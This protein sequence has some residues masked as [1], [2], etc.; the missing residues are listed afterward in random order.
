[1]KQTLPIQGPLNHMVSASIGEVVCFRPSLS[2]PRPHVLQAA[3]LIRVPTE[4]IKT[5]TQTS[6]YGTSAASS[7]ASAKLLLQNDGIKGLYRG[8]GITVMREVR[9][10]PL[11]DLFL[12]TFNLE[13]TL[14]FSAVSSV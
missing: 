5:R 14:H 11:V 4:V 10:E 3:C 8:F 1:M 12:L 7:L 2:L 13:D 9:Q 6:S